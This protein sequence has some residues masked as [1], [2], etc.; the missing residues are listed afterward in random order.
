[1]FCAKQFEKDRK[2]SKRRKEN[3]RLVRFAH[4][5]VSC[6]E[7]LSRNTYYNKRDTIRAYFDLFQNCLPGGD[8]VTLRAIKSSSCM[9]DATSDCALKIA[10]HSL[11]D[12]VAMRLPSLSVRPRLYAYPSIRNRAVA[13]HYGCGDTASFYLACPGSGSVFLSHPLVKSTKYLIRIFDESIIDTSQDSA[14]YIII[15]NLFIYSRNFES[16]KINSFFNSQKDRDN[17]YSL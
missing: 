1:M 12:Y 10:P 2:K 3:R 6:D 16:L 15:I 7:C 5:G 11:S 14:I 8:A 13:G 9:V 17:N 4:I